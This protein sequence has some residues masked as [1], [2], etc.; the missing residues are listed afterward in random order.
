MIHL[1]YIIFLSYAHS[2]SS[3]P[4]L[5]FVKEDGVYHILFKLGE[6]NVNLPLSLE[7]DYIV[8][9]TEKYKPKLSRTY[10]LIHENTVSTFKGLMKQIDFTDMLYLSN[11]F[12]VNIHCFL[13]DETN[14]V[15]MT[16]AEFGLSPTISRVEYSLIHLL[17]KNE[18]IRILGFTLSFDKVENKGV[19]YFGDIPSKV[20]QENNYIGKCKI[21][22]MRSKWGCSLDKVLI[23]DSSFINNKYAYFQT[24]KDFISIPSDFYIYLYENV[25]TAYIIERKCK[26]LLSSE[27]NVSL[28]CDCDIIEDTPSFTF[29]FQNSPF[30]IEANKLF[31]RNNFNQCRLIMNSN[32]NANEWIFGT[33]FLDKYISH[34][35]YET[36]E[37]TFFSINQSHQVRV[38]KNCYIL[39]IIVIFFG[40]VML[41]I[42]SSKIKFSYKRISNNKT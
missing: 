24:N 38:N 15:Q 5:P 37:I 6:A 1:L 32:S 28:V 10:Q 3:Y 35:N 12:M 19:I 13:M 9:N 18:H 29:V 16:N 39:L 42:V 40:F 30:V 22:N 25:F 27:F 17:K 21:N 20:I 14:L 4:S 34:Y 2:L 36:K 11:D 23:G 7:G 31:I 8:V 41:Y 33:P 26:E